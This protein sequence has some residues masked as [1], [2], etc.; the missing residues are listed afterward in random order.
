MRIT[1]VYC[2]AAAVA[3]GAVSICQADTIIYA[4][5]AG[6]SGVQVYDANTGVVTRT[7]TT[8]AMAS[9]NGRGVVVVGNIMYCT[10][11][12][13]PSVFAYNLQTNAD[14]GSVFTVA[15]ASGFATMAYD[16]TNLYLGD[17]GGTNNVYRRLL[18]IFR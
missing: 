3:F 12:S 5:S 14:L 8:S 13:S 11:A 17:Y 18:A 1:S 2:L 6:T 7:I 10:A 9:N 16:G 15:G 4:N